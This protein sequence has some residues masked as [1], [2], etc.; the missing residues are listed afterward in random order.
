MNNILENYNNFILHQSVRSVLI[1]SN[2]V[3]LPLVSVCIP[4]YNRPK[5][6]KNSI[7]SVLNQKI[8]RNFE[9]IIVDNTENETLLNETKDVIISYIEE[10]PKNN[11]YY[12][13][14][15]KNIGMYGNWNRCI[16]LANCNR[17]TI[18]N[19]DDRFRDGVFSNLNI[20]HFNSLLAFDRLEIRNRKIETNF[21]KDILRFAKNFPMTCRGIKPSDFMLGNPFTSSLGIF[22]MKNNAI[23]LG[24]FSENFYPSCDYHFFLRYILFYGGIYSSKKL[25]LYN[26]EENASLH[27]ETLKNFAKKSKIIRK[28][29]LHCANISGINYVLYYLT[30]KYV[31]YIH[32]NKPNAIFYKLVLL[33][34]FY[35][36]KILNL[37]FYFN[38]RK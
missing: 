16:E 23:K 6:L 32:G 3:S 10:F 11:I 36:F 29:L 7:L 9:V 13:K 26:W 4:T 8:N 12:Y 27:P 28:E 24:G 20:Y 31:T 19:D 33:P 25:F 1:Y 17:M 21:L 37:V 34:F 22:F 5:L 35:F 15:E 14:N 30:F 38:V 2:K 18:L